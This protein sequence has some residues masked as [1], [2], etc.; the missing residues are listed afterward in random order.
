[1]TKQVTMNF[2]LVSAFW[3]QNQKWFTIEGI[4]FCSLR[5]LLPAAI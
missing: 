2:V 3:Q 5:P 1:M 4:H